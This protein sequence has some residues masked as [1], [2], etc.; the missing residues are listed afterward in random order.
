M[1]YNPLEIL[2]SS[3]VWKWASNVT[4]KI[5]E[6]VVLRSLASLYMYGPRIGDVGFWQGKKPETIC[7]HLTMSPDDFWIRNMEECQ[8]IISQHFSSWVI[9]FEIIVYFVLL[10]K[11]VKCL[12]NLVCSCRARGGGG[13]KK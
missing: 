1:S 7:S 4:R 5:Y 6:V 13:I 10:W 2:E 11:V 12:V 8:R 3:S 9:L